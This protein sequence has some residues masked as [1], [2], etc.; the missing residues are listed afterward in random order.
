MLSRP[1]VLKFLLGFEHPS[2]KKVNISYGLLENDKKMLTIHILR[3]ENRDSLLK[4]IIV[5]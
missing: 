2:S 4:H 3:L 1:D 5:K